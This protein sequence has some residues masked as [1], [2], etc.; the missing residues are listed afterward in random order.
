MVVV[1]VIAVTVVVVCEAGLELG[2]LGQ[3]QALL[4]GEVLLEITN[5]LFNLHHGVFHPFRRDDAQRI[6]RRD[7]IVIGLAKLAVVAHVARRPV[8]LLGVD[9]NA[10]RFR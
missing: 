10:Q 9:L 3:Q 5:L 1:A 4:H 6:H 8:K 2:A 7:Q